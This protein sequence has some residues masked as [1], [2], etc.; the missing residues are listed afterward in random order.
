[1]IFEWVGLGLFPAP[2]AYPCWFYLKVVNSDGRIGIIP[3]VSLNY[4]KDSSVRLFLFQFPYI[5]VTHFCPSNNSVILLD[6]CLRSLY[7]NSAT[8]ATLSCSCT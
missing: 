5:L 6:V 1:L 2:M 8:T 4:C 7:T 3:G